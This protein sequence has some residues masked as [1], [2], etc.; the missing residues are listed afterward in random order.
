MEWD[1]ICPKSH[2]TSKD[3]NMNIKYLSLLALIGC[4]TPHDPSMTATAAKDYTLVSSAC[5]AMPGRGADIC[6]VK[7]NTQIASSW[8][9]VLPKD[10]RLLGGEINVYYKDISRSYA[11]DSTVTEIPW[12]DLLGHDTWS[13]DDN[14]TALALAQI[15]FK[16]NQGVE[17]VVR[18]KGLA[19]LVV[20]KEGYDPMPIDSGFEAF[21]TRCRIQ[22]SDAGRSALSCK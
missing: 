3:K 13:I 1:L 16:D 18:A 9:I 15:R 19:I 7:E 14:G 6:R 2:S 12:R 22:Y 17:T 11:I 5:E 4:V 10:K 20:T 21:S 8:K